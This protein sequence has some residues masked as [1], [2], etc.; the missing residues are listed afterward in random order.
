MGNYDTCAL[1]IEELLLKEQDILSVLLA[2]QKR[3]YESVV[4][5]DWVMLQKEAELS[6]AISNSFLS[7]EEQRKQVTRPTMK[8]VG[9]PKDFY[10]VTANFAPDVRSRLND[11]FRDIKRL[12]LLSKTENDVFNAYISNARILVSGIIESAVPARRNRIYSRHGSLV[13]TNVESLVLNRS[14]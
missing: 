6:Q 8:G 13:S 5:R 1:Q 4:I 10:S 12:L 9:N 7:L 3:M 2:C 11:L 14:F